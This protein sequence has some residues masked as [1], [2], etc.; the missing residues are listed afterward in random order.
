M[1]I[2]HFC[3]LQQTG[4]WNYSWLWKKVPNA[5]LI[6]IWQ[7]GTLS[8]KQFIAAIICHKEN[9]QTKWINCERG[10]NK[11]NWKIPEVNV[12]IFADFE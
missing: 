3:L 1:N 7:R 2:A 5:L 11:K 4:Q 12:M 6:K 8:A 9:G 10:V